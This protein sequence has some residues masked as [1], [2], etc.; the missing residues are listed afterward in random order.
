VSGDE[1]PGIEP[2]LPV[3]GV[4]AATAAG[5]YPAP[6]NVTDL[7]LPGPE[8]FARR[9]RPDTAPRRRRGVLAHSG[10]RFLQQ[11]LEAW[12]HVRT[13]GASTRSRRTP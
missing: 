11:L 1:N 13:G 7:P 9:K 2:W 8:A 4:A 3:I 12:R 10:L 6:H 5:M